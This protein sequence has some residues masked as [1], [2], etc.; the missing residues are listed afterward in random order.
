MT[1]S[2]GIGSRLRHPNYGEG[3]LMKISLEY[4][5]ISFFNIGVKEI[6]K[7]FEGLELIE[8]IEPEHDAISFE[9]IEMKL[10]E[11]LI[12]WADV[13]ELV[14]IAPKYIGGTMYLQPSDKSL[15]P[16][17]IPITAFFHK[18]VMLRDRL[19]VLEQKINAHSILSDEEK[20]EMQQ[21]ITRIYGSLTTFNVLF[22]DTNHQ[23]VG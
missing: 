18:I 5:T 6:S 21:Y 14:S 11:I 7:T 4:F 22:K 10:S 8:A 3:I 13:Q 9:A 17:D 1:S 23:F 20:V 16:K 12:K 19:R 15:K 2:L